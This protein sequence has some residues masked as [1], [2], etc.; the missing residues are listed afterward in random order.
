MENFHTMQINDRLVVLPIYVD[1]EYFETRQATVLGIGTV[2]AMNEFGVATL[3]IKDTQINEL[4]C[5][6]LAQAAW[7][8]LCQGP[9]APIREVDELDP[10]AYLNRLN[11]FI[12]QR[13]SDQQTPE[14]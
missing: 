13:Y 10:H 8:K 4:D 5:R 11:E 9:N 12:P 3:Q 1:L 7:R 2:V 6:T 14:S